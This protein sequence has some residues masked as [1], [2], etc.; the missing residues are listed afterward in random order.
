MSVINFQDIPNDVGGL[1]F[2][3]LKVREVCVLAKTSILLNAFSQISLRRERIVFC[4][5]FGIPKMLKLCP[6]VV[7]ICHTLNPREEKLRAVMV[8]L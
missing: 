7:R 5:I 3:Y 4:G 2:E 6:S 1:I 8:C